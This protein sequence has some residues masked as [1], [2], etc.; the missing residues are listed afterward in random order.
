MVRKKFWEKPINEFIRLVGAET[1]EKLVVVLGFQFIVFPGVFSPIFS[2]DSAWFAEKLIPLIQLKE[3]LEIGS[4]SGI[5]ACIAALHG[6]KRVIATDINPEAIKN[7]KANSKLHAL[8]VETR[9]GSVF[10]PILKNEKFDVIF[11]N[12]PF[13][14]EKG[15][16][17]SDMLSK[18]VFDFEYT[19]LRKF[20]KYGKK[21]LK[22]NGQLIL[23][24]SNVA[25]INTIKMLARAEKY[26]IELLEKTD[27]PIYKGKKIKMDIRMYSLHPK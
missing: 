22:P 7:I 26:T 9:E 21:L 24:T 10:D 20:F 12:H 17:E 2:S 6:A 4:G 15:E 25:R 16:N 8:K 18:S 19:S 5:I 11:W 13:Y 27:V 23:G 14:F 3:F 1:E